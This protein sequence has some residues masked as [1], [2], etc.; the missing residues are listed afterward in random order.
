MAQSAAK[1]KQKS[2]LSAGDW[3][4]QALVLIAEKGIRSVA[5]ESLAKRMG[6]TKGSF[7]WHFPNRDALLGQSLLRWEKHDE[8]NLQASLGA[9]ND[10]RERLRSFFRQTGRG[11]LTHDVYS[12]LCT[13]ADHPKVEPLLERVAERRMNHIQAAFEEIG[14][15]VAE[16]SHRARLTYSTYLGFLQLQRQHQAPNLSSEEFEAY[17]IHVIATLIPAE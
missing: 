17:M 16:A 7:Y 10:P 9:I 12:T 3:E 8:V 5:I 15:S 2:T 14:F 1:K 4:Q 11:S 6:V 13:A